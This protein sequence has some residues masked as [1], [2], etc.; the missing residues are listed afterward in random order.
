MVLLDVEKKFEAVWLESL[1]I[2]LKLYGFPLL[3]IKLLHSYWS[4]RLVRV[5]VNRILYQPRPV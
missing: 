1:E 4:G 5:R 3:I 2:K